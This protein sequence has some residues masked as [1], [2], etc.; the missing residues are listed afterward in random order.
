MKRILS[1]SLVLSFFLLLAGGAVAE[2]VLGKGVSVN[3]QPGWEKIA[4]KGKAVIVLASP[5]TLP[6]FRPNINVIIE[7]ARVKTQAEYDK[8]NI[9]EIKKAGGKVGPARDFKLDNGMTGKQ[10]NW[11]LDYQGKSMKFFSFWMNIKGQA[12]IFTGTAPLEN[13]S[14]FETEFEATCKTLKPL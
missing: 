13:F 12:Y 7:P 2:E 10:M 9:E 11:S 4:P 14:E 3:S 5:K 1:V 6:G 8:T